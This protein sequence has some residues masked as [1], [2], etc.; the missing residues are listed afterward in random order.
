[1]GVP[2]PISLILIRNL[3]W[4]TTTRATT[5]CAEMIRMDLDGLGRGEP[6]FAHFSGLSAFSSLVKVQFCVPLVGGFGGYLGFCL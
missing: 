3:E 5:A 4:D 6:D 2:N 1:M